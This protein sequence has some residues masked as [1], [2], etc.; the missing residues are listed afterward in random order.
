MTRAWRKQS[1]NNERCVT[2]SVTPSSDERVMMRKTEKNFNIIWPLLLDFYFTSTIT[3][4]LRLVLTFVGVNTKLYR[5]TK[6][7]ALPGEFPFW[8]SCL[9]L[10]MRP[11]F[12]G[13]MP[14]NSCSTKRS[15]QHQE[16]VFSA[17]VHLGGDVESHSWAIMIFRAGAI[18]SSFTSHTFI[19]VQR[20]PTKQL[21]RIIILWIRG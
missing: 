16:R 15:S 9:L 8:E 13:A 18:I 3:V 1:R 4:I 2:N 6:G 20:E 10:R 7:R 5:A 17:E 11:I 19:T 14:I 21:Q 12:E